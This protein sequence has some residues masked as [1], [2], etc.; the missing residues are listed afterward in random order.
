[1]MLA[2][3]VGGV[4]S[5]SAG[6]PLSLKRVAARPLPCKGAVRRGGGRERL[7][8]G[9]GNHGHLTRSTLS[10]FLSFPLKE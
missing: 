5:P 6:N 2:G 3:G 10:A 1:M 9:L 7:R 8:L 4:R